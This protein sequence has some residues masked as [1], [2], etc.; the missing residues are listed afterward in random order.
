GRELVVGAAELER[1]RALQ[2]FRLEK[3]APPGARI[4]RGRG[5]EGRSQGN[6]S[7]APRGRIDIGRSR[8]RVIG[9]GLHRKDGSAGMAC[10]A[11]PAVT[12]VCG[13]MRRQVWTWRGGDRVQSP[14]SFFPTSAWIDPWISEFPAARLLCVLRAAGLAAPAPLRL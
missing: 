14:S 12:A 10:P 13:S 5:D 3:H 11:R 8:Q 2:G 6:A 7:K 1:P 4:E 9:R